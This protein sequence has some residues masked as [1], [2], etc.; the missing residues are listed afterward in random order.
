MTGQ[1]L[2]MMWRTPKT[3]Y[4]DPRVASQNG[5]LCLRLSIYK[6]CTGIGSIYLFIYVEK[7]ILFVIVAADITFYFSASEKSS[8]AGF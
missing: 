3:K 1:F 8:T 7:E 6:A 2:P 4:F 5:I